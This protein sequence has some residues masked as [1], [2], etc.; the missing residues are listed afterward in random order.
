M[1]EN[2]K[3][4]NIKLRSLGLFP[5]S[6]VIL[7]KESIRLH[8]YQAQFKALVNDCFAS[9]NDFVVP[10]VYEGKQTNYGTCVKLV[11]VERF[12]PD[13]KMDIKVEGGS[14]VRVSNVSEAKNRNYFTGEVERIDSSLPEIHSEELKDLFQKYCVFN[15]HLISLDED[16]SLYGMARKIKLDKETKIKL[17][18]NSSNP[19]VQSK[20]ILNELRL[21]VLTHELQDAAGFRYYM[22]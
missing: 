11:D 20:I 14:I 1:F 7:P 9:G 8:I 17:L 15:N 3:M 6:M 13:G 12:Y 21:L 16:Y 4:K 5:L 19:I 10:F 18:R 2:M 22:N